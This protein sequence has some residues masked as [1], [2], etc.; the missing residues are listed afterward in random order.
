MSQQNAPGPQDGEGRANDLDLVD[1]WIAFWR[2]RRLFALVFVPIAVLGILLFETRYEPAG[3]QSVRSVVELREKSLLGHS[4]VFLGF[5][6]LLANR[7]RT[8]DL[9]ELAS[10]PEYEEARAYLAGTSVQAIQDTNLVEIVSRA[11]PGTI[12]L[13]VAFHEALL[14]QVA[15]DLEA[16]SE[17]LDRSMR[18]N[19]GMLQ[20]RLFRLRTTV[21]E[22]DALSGEA[23]ASTGEAPRDSEMQARLATMDLQLREL[24]DG[25][26]MLYGALHS[27]GELRSVEARILVLAS[28]GSLDTG[29]KPATAYVL[30]LLFAAF[31]SLLVLVLNGFAALVRERSAGR[32]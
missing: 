19:F 26:A 28:V 31:L 13:V 11:P 16:S 5:A 21:A 22:M 30:I 27:I 18:G 17:G 24:S 12:D 6:E 20:E 29:L 14:R 3:Y 9:P 10:A 25:I 23:D 7:I 4:T 2:S 1:L 15:L 32:N 8:V